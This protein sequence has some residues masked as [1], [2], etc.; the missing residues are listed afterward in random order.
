[1]PIPWTSDVWLALF[2]PFAIAFV[3]WRF[4]ASL[5][6]PRTWSE[7][8]DLVSLNPDE[9]APFSL[10]RA[11]NTY[12]RY[13]SLSVLEASR[14][15]VSY[16]STSRAHK[17]LGYTLGYPAKLDRLAQVTN[18]NGKITDAIA[19]LAEKEFGLDLPP[20][21]GT[22]MDL[23]RVREALKHFIRDWSS[24]GIREREKIFTPILDVLRKVDVDE[25][26]RM[27]VLVPGSGLGRLAWEISELGFLET[28][29]NEL[30][31]FMNLAL[32]FLLSPSTTSVPNE[33]A[34]HPYAHWF[35]H[36]R[37]A[38]SLFRSISFPDAVPRLSSSFKLVEK[39]FLTLQ[40]PA[41]P[42][43][44]LAPIPGYDYIVTLFFIDTSLNIL[45]TLEHI[46]HLL[47]PGGTWINLGPLLWTGGAQSKLELS[48]E[49]VLR[50]AEEVGFI[51]DTQD[52]G[53][54]SKTVE[55][56]YTGDPQAMMRWIYRAEF[57]VARKPK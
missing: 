4:S 51:I 44:I 21:G 53:Q 35:S 46:Y 30:S 56:E 28:T 25:R 17:R 13:R 52:D 19:R 23:M 14:L 20:R 9:S 45:T 48:L 5:P 39:D 41:A 12:A 18:A 32:R 55:C 16:A 37:S 3:G 15:Q 29:A 6:V 22:A 8:R 27:R 50:A 54:P 31:F 49:E 57:W 11:H 38:E 26:A 10:Q 36:Q 7:L 2:L 47:R 42:S 1:M 34:I 40:P 33:H 24:D 43:P